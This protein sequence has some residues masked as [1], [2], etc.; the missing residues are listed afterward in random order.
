MIKKENLRDQLISA[1]KELVQNKKLR[2]TIG[3]SA[4]AYIHKNHEIN[5]MTEK[6]DKYLQRFIKE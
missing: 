6:L 3:K 5:I 4:S 2:T 1:I